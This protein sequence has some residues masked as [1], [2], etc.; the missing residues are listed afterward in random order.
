MI[1]DETLAEI[2][3]VARRQRAERIMRTTDIGMELERRGTLFLLRDRDG[4]V[5]SILEDPPHAAAVQEWLRHRLAAR[6]DDLLA[7][8][9]DDLGGAE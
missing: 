4:C 6:A 3:A 2:E 1:S 7:G 5:L 9:L 8:I